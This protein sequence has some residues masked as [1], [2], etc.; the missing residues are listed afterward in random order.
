MKIGTLL[1]EFRISQSKTK[2]EW[3]GNV[4]SPSFYARVEKGANRISS[5]DLIKLL[6]YNKI[7]L[8][9]FFNRFD[10]SMQLQSKAT[11]EIEYKIKQAYYIDS[12]DKLYQVRK[13]IET[14]ELSNKKEELL[15][16]DIGIALVDNDY[17]SLDS[18]TKKILKEKIFEV[19]N[20]S[21]DN[22]NLYC[23]CMAWFDLTT[24]LMISK[25][26]VNNFI[27]DDPKVQ[28]KILAVIINILLLC[29]K[30]QQFDEVAFFIK[31][32]NEVDILPE[33]YFY[34]NILNFLIHLI[35]YCIN[36]KTEELSICNAIISN[37]ATNGMQKYSTELKN[38]LKENT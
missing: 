3:A 15:L 20:F 1:K 33:N 10:R 7:S 25:K 35:N 24:N 29:I 36:S 13:L 19:E 32:A 26:I 16:V 23:N 11:R 12:K 6:Q 5:E 34:K 37:F 27:D 9:K 2:K 17:N 18:K 21:K 31:K 8:T 30:Q 22:I 14:S 28:N 4:I 38:L